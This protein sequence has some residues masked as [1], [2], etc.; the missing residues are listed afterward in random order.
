MSCVFNSD[1][2]LLFL[3][4][5]SGFKFQVFG[6]P[7]RL[8]FSRKDAKSQKLHPEICVFASLR[9]F[10]SF[11]LCMK[12]VM[13]LQSQFKACNA[14]STSSHTFY[15]VKFAL[16]QL[17]NVGENCLLYNVHLVERFQ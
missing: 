3:F 12:I 14:S 17:K 2:K 11:F 5:V 7:K 16:K 6:L 9:D 15:Q 4:Q 13:E 1:A 8:F 10:L